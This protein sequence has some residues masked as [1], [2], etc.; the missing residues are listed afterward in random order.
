[1]RRVVADGWHTSQYLI[2]INL[3][4]MDKGYD[5]VKTETPR[6]KNMSDNVCQSI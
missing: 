6:A 2:N 5:A 1:M 3:V 4:T